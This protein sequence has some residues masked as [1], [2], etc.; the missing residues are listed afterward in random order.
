VIVGGGVVGSSVAWN[1]RRDGFRGRIVAIERDPTYRH[2]SSYNATGGIRHQYGSALNVQMATY[3][4]AFYARFDDTMGTEARRPRSWFRRRGYL[5]LAGHGDEAQFETRLERL[6]AAGAPVER[7]S[8]D[9]VHERLPDVVVDDVAFGIFGAQDGYLNPREVLAGFRH[10]AEAAG[11]EFVVGEVIGVERQG[12]AV[13]GV[14][15]RSE[16]PNGSAPTER[17]IDAPWVVVAAGA[18]SASV[19]AL[20]GVE[21]PIVP[22]RQHLYRLALERTLSY[23]FPL[24]FDPTGLY[25]RHDD[26]IE[27]GGSDG[28]IFGRS[29]TDE[30]AGVNFEID[31]ET[32]REDLLPSL[33]RRIP[34]FSNATLI[35][36]RVGLYEMTPDHNGIVGEHPELR[37]LLM[38]AGFSGHGLM[39]APATGKAISEII[40]RGRSETFDVGPLDPGRFA[41]G[42]LF[43]DDALI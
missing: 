4:A 32:F 17:R 31:Y 11:A 28:F 41:R 38:A 24:T 22:V 3:S 36:A 15:I 34:A 8:V 6:L 40:V 43:L 29:K 20:A 7:W 35:E 21:L 33:H 18:F 9:R 12:D 26:P 30:P 27:T 2:A 5:F 16:M 42:E 19:G 14:V 13:A 1:L 10:A 39:M 25:M 23:R 37:G